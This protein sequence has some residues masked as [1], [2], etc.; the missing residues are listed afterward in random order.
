MQIQWL[1]H[2]AF[3]IADGDTRILIDPFLNGN[4]KFTG[5]YAATIADAT[6]VCLTHMHNDHFGDTMDILRRTKA[7]LVCLVEIADWVGGKLGTANVVDINF[8][9][10]AIVD[11]VAVSLVPAVHTSGL[12]MEDGTAVFGGVSAGLVIGVGD[13]T[14]YHMGDTTIFGDMALID[15][16]HHPDIGIVPIGGHYT[17]DARIAALAVNRYFN[18]DTVLP[19]HYLTF[20]LLAQSAD[21]FVAAV[22]GPNVLTP[23]PMETVE[24]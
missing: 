1:G 17:M 13:H 10:T 15:E 4:P 20:P 14:I 9:G 6:H 21:A 22:K 24:V 8:G 7:K 19:C 11:G 23:A 3:K 2:S 5:D 12:T 18:F 16:L